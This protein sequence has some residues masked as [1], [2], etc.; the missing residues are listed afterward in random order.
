MVQ[1]ISLNEIGVEQRDTSGIQSKSSMQ[2]EKLSS[3][4]EKA[5]MINL[6][7]KFDI[8]S[9]ENIKRKHKPPT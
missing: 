5:S 1:N 8:I 7:K 3:Q 4:L 2:T 6:N 9:F